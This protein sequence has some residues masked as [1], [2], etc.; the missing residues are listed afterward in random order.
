M[1]VSVVGPPAWERI[2]LWTLS[3]ARFAL[4]NTIGAR[5]RAQILRLSARGDLV[6]P[7]MPETPGI[8]PPDT[9]R[10]PADMPELLGRAVFRPSRVWHGNCFGEGRP[11]SPASPSPPLLP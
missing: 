4:G 3:R 10:T 2:G 9:L 5:V 6:Q 1:S 7:T 11:Q 8:C